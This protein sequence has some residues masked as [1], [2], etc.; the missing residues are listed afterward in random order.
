MMDADLLGYLSSRYR[1]GGETML[2]ATVEAWLADSRTGLLARL[3]GAGQTGRGDDPATA[4]LRARIL[5]DV[6]AV[7]EPD[8]RGTLETVGMP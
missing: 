8:E 6:L 3:G 4:G 7:L 1:A 5:R 2:L